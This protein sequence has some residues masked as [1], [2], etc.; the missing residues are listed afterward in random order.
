MAGRRTGR[1][2]L[3]VIAAGGTGGHM[4]PAQALAEALLARGWRV[5]LSTDERGARYAGNFALAV[6]RR[7]VPSATPARGGATEKLLVPLRIAGG[8]LKAAAAM[9]LDRPRVVVGFG[10][11]PS[12]PALAAAWLLRIPRLIHEQNGVLGRVNEAFARRVQVVACG[13]W[14]TQLPGGV[15]GVH[16]GN[17]VREAVR[18]R[19]A[20]PY[21][22]PGDYPVSVVVIGGSQGARILSDIVPD[23]LALLPEALRGVEQVEWFAM[24]A[25][26]P[27]KL[28]LGPLSR[29]FHGRDL[30]APLAALFAAGDLGPGD[31][32]APARPSDPNPIPAPVAAAADIT[33]CIVL[34]DHFG[35]LF[36]NISA[37]AF[38]RW[39]Q[40]VVE[41]GRWRLPLSGTY[42][43]AD[44][45]AP[46][47]LVNAY[48]LVEIA[49]NGG[50]AAA[51]LGL[52]PGDAVRLR[53]G[54][55]A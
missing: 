49:V 25:D 3:A 13:A 34:A 45:G 37:G 24:R 17:P 51:T 33:G 23:S 46:L 52:A 22:A 15:E 7:V 28:G 42:G 29:T 47:A 9:V 19:A 35:N 40:P 41:A 4:F 12:I 6:T 2:P 43:E 10:G 26:L 21:I 31:F 53:D 11:Y 55:P 16:V 48:G 32:G 20:S 14:P 44:A 36:T 5:Q 30:F 50:S 38:A 8:V 54:L 18:E 39:R 1:A 27:G